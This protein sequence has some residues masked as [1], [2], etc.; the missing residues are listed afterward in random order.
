M[1]VLRVGSV[2]GDRTEVLGGLTATDSVVVPA[3]TGRP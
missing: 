2:V 1:T 3:V